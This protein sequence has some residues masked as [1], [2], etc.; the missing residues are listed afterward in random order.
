MRS[1]SWKTIAKREFDVGDDLLF[2]VDVGNTNIVMGL[3]DGDELIEHWRVGTTPIRTTDELG[4]LLLTL[5]SARGIETSR[6]SA[7]ICGCVVPPAV[8]PVRRACQRYFGVEPRFVLDDVPAPIPIRYDN[9]R[10]VGA[11]RIV[12]AVAAYERFSTACV[13]VDFGTATTFDAVAADGGYEGGVIAPGLRISMDALY[14]RASA[15]PRV[16]I[17]KPSRAIG[18]TTV[19][20]MQAGT[21]FGYT[22]LVDGIVARLIDELGPGDVHVVATGGL[23]G[24]IAQDSRFI[25]AALPF[26]TLEGLRSLHRL[27]AG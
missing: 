5:F 20:A 22:G 4:A 2:V 7:A 11:D 23:A 15:L 3:Y 19:A 25:E 18:K 14:E 16:A 9:P 12:N 17:R 8:H 1:E 21:I 13:I 6:I 27:Q 10:E 24:L 26:L